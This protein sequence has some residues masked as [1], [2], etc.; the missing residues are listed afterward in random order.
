MIIRIDINLPKRL[1][2]V[3]SEQATQRY[4]IPEGYDILI[5]DL[6]QIVETS[7]TFAQVDPRHWWELHHDRQAERNRHTTSKFYLVYIGAQVFGECYV[8]WTC[9]AEGREEGRG[10]RGNGDEDY[11]GGAITDQEMDRLSSNLAYT[12]E[13][14]VEKGYSLKGPWYIRA[15]EDE[16]TEALVQ[17][18]VSASWNK[19]KRWTAVPLNQ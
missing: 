17:A 10:Y 5:S 3:G 18:R 4:K 12:E 16:E 13:V 7:A 8:E 1:F 9:D 11:L 19:P 14:A 15:L 6:R 2:T